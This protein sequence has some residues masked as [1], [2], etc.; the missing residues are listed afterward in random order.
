MAETAPPAPAAP[1]P[2]S[3]DPS[4]PPPAR[5][6]QLGGGCFIT[7]GLLLGPAVGLIFGQVTAGLLIGGA[8]GIVA[9]IGFVV[10]AAR[11]KD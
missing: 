3:T 10:A 4:V 6:P 9:A 5:P 2:V 1:A 11:R 7:A 8:L